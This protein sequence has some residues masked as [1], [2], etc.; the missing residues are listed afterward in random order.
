MAAMGPGSH[1]RSVDASGNLTID[2]MTD[3][4]QVLLDLRPFRYRQEVQCPLLEDG[5]RNQGGCVREYEA[6]KEE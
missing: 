5:T 6:G 4:P 3:P 1:L 2:V